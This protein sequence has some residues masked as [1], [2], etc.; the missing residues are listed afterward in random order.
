VIL[1]HAHFR[2]ILILSLSK[3]GLSKDELPKG[4]KNALLRM[5]VFE[6]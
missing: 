2:P 5:R 1:R 4:G 3:D 6:S